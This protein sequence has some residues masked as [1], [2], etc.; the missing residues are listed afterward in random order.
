MTRQNVIVIGAG[1]AGLAAASKLVERGHAVTLIEA[2]D[3]TG[4]RILTVQDEALNVPI[5]LGAEFI[6]GISPEIWVPL[7]NSGAKIVEVEGE[8]WCH[9][10]SEL[11]P[12]D[13]WGQMESIL[14]K[15]DDEEPDTSFLAFLEQ[16]FP[17]PHNDPRLQQAK[18]RAQNYVIGFNAADPGK[19]GVHWLVRGMRAEEEIEGDRAF[20][21]A[22]GYETLLRHFRE[23]IK[24]SAD[25]RTNSVV[26]QVNWKQGHV[27]LVVRNDGNEQKLTAAQVLV[28]VPLAMLKGALGDSGEIQFNPPLPSAKLSAMQKI[29]VGHVVRI[30]L[31][32][33]ERFWNTIC[34]DSG[35]KTLSRMSFLFSQDEW[36]PTWWTTMPAKLPIITGWAPFRAAESLSGKGKSFVVQ[37]ALLSLCR[38]LGIQRQELETQLQAAY[39][40]DWQTDPFSRG[41][42]SYGGIGSD[43][44]QQALAAPVESTLFFAGEAADVTGN[45]GTVHGAIASGYRAANEI[46]EA[47]S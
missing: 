45:N 2:R 43:G 18:Q 19:V 32:F 29:E 44:A 17:N 37:R 1:M 41:A 8:S 47:I 10:N 9:E 28:T 21:C 7:Q 35:K 34:P 42:Y 22:G 27:E 38:L 11:K 16:R 39:F 4:G 26:H 15:M 12:C 23:K 5:E 46:V 20:R 40:H 3:R 13:F 36:F 6:H 33:R 14:D 31:R 25:I 30:V 24:G